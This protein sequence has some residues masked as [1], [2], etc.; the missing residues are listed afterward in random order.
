MLQIEV[1]KEYL[2]YEPDSGKFFW[3]KRSSDKNKPGSRAGRARSLRGYRQV[4]LLGVTMYEHR[5]AWM[6]CH[7]ELPLGCCIDHIN[8]VKGDNRIDNLRLASQFE[9]AANVGAKKDNTSGHKNVHWCNAKGRWIA[10]VK[11]QGK[12]IYAGSF[13][14]YDAAVMAANETRIKVHGAF[15]SQLGC[16]ST[17]ARE[18]RQQ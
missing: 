14:D 5:L 13:T 9:N 17:P 10:K 11:R 1:I 18:L 16:E 7:G 4:T 8:G 12:T 6:Y 2:R 3:V 15:A